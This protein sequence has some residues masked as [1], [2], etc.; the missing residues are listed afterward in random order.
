MLAL[1][2]ILLEHALCVVEETI[3]GIRESHGPKPARIAAVQPLIAANVELALK[4]LSQPRLWRPCTLWLSATTELE[5]V[6][7]AMPVAVHV[8]VAHVNLL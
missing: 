8:L 3:E 5:A 1:V 2:P 6:K 4:E 7:I